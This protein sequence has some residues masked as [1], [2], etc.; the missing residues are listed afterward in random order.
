[1]RDAA[2][3][4]ARQVDQHQVLGALLGVGQFGSSATSRSGVRR[5]GGCRP[6]GGW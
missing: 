4:V 6:A 3:V 1:V 2:D 5:A